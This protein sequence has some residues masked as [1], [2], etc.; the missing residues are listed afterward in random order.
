MRDIA[1]GRLWQRWQVA[2]LSLIGASYVCFAATY[3]RASS[4]KIRNFLV[5][6]FLCAAVAGLASRTGVMVRDIQCV[7]TSFPNFFDLMDSITTK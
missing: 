7:G 2:T 3:A 4:K 6:F 1:T 5:G